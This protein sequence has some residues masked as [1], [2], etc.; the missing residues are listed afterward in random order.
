MPIASELK[1]LTML[2]FKNRGRS[3]SSSD[4]AATKGTLFSEPRPGLPP[5]RSPEVGV[6]DL[7]GPF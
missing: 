3:L 5:A 7:H 2:S 1:P 4:T 6:V